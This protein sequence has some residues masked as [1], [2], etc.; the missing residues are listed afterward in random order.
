MMLMNSPSGMLNFEYRYRFCGLPNGVSIPPRFAAIVWSINTY[1]M[2]F[3]LPE[4][5]RTKYPSGRNVRSA[6]SFAMNIEPMKVM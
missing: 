4:L 1:A 6:M 3:F 2:Y 5:S